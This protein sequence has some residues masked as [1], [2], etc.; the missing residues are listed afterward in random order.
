M[1]PLFFLCHSSSS[2]CCL[3]VAVYL[4][5]CAACYLSVYLAVSQFPPVFPNYRRSGKIWGNIST[6]KGPQDALHAATVY[7]WQPGQWMSCHC[8]RMDNI[9][10]FIQLLLSALL[11]QLLFIWMSVEGNYVLPVV[12]SA[13][14]QTKFWDTCT[15]I[16]LFSNISSSLHLHFTVSVWG[17]SSPSRCL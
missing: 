16:F 8:W 10:L 3:Q 2:L 12:E 6:S 13:F 1:W 15:L 5:S 14:T 9:G 17:P 11:F 7:K 4:C